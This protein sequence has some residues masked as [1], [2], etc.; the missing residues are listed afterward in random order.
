MKRNLHIVSRYI[1]GV[2]K[3]IR[4]SQRKL[5]FGNINIKEHKQFIRKLNIE[6][7]NYVFSLKVLKQNKKNFNQIEDYDREREREKIKFVFFSDW[8]K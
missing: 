1:A 4:H 7:I 5:H 2:S 8:L 3:L 6:R